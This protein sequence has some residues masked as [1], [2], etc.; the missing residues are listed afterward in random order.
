MAWIVVGV[1]LLSTGIVFIYFVLTESIAGLGR[2]IMNEG[3]GSKQRT[4]FV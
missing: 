4:E 2:Q 1:T 3:A